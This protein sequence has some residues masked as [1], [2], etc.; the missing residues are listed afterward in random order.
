MGVVGHHI[1]ICEDMAPG[2]LICSAIVRPCIH[3]IAIITK[4]GVLTE[5]SGKSLRAG[6]VVRHAG[7]IGIFSTTW[8]MQHALCDSLI[9]QRLAY[10]IWQLS[11]DNAIHLLGIVDFV[12]LFQEDE[13]MHVRKP[14][15]LELND[16]DIS[17]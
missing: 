8:A 5:S 9:Q 13:K 4:Y 16:I 6:G 1:L 12:L 2:I 10:R 15:L 17:S 11:R 14:P 3:W 7:D